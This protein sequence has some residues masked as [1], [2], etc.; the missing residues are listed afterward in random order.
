MLIVLCIGVLSCDMLYRRVP[1]MLLLFALVLHV[2]FLVCT[3]HGISGIDVWQS[4]VGGTV[5]FIFFLPLYLLRA[6]GAGDV[7]FFTLLGF[8][9]GARHLLPIWLAASLMAGA[10]AVLWYALK[11]GMA[12]QMLPPGV[13]YLLQRV[14]VS[15]PYQAMLR[16][17]G[18]RHGIPY[19]AYLALAAIFATTAA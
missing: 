19:A 15:G 17:R 12:E 5:A 18:G 13:Q 1:N 2:G 8:L 3:G 6:M 7:K 14:A 16:R 10:H 4:M 9:L 11:N